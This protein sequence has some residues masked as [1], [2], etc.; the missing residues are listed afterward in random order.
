MT[1][2]LIRR[3][4]M[5]LVTLVASTIGVSLLIHVVPGD[6]VMMMM[7]QNAAATPEQIER[8][9]H[10]LGLDLPVWQQTLHYIGNILQGDFGR[11]IFGMEPVSTLLFDRLPN[12]LALAFC[13]M[14]IAVGIG[15]PL[16][17]YSAYRQGTW[18]DN[19]LMLGA[20]FGVSIPSF[21]L[22]L[23][24]LLFFSLT[25]ELL[26]VASGDYR[27]L[28]LPAITLGVTYAAI[29]ARMTRSAMIEV[30]AEDY[31]RTAR[32]KGLP[33]AIVLRRHALKPSLI[34]VVTIVAV[35]FGYLMGGAVVVEN[36]FSWNGLGRLALEA[37]L[38]RD[39]PVIQGFILLFAA[40]IVIIS[41]IIDLAYAW[42]DPRITY[43]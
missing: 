23:I 21:W 34:A 32:A 28:A 13:S 41:I 36:V 24:L 19:V 38:R 17:F 27:S 12:T 8:V 7:A 5:A 25:L 14:A 15:L 10:A 31:I 33:E 40:V 4:I 42:L 3:L 26:P 18:V 35:V 39:Y 22:G 29:I 16:G 2:Y 6:P 9:R 1:Y 20:V 11:S 37:I 30:F 43:R